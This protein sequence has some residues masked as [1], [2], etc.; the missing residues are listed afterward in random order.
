MK[1]I[2][3][4][5]ILVSICFLLSIAFTSSAQKTADFSLTLSPNPTNYTGYPSTGILNARLTYPTNAAEV[6]ANTFAVIVTAGG[7]VEFNISGYTP[8]TG[9]AIDVANTDAANVVFYNTAALVT[10]ATPLTFAIPTKAVKAGSTVHGGDIQP[11]GNI[12]YDPATSNNLP[13]VTVNVPA[14]PLPVTLISFNAIKENNTANLSWSTSSEV[15]SNRFEI[16][17]SVDAKQWKVVGTVASYQN[18]TIRQNYTFNHS[19]PAAGDNYY[20]LKMIDNDETFAFSTIK[21]LT[22]DQSLSLTL[23]PNPVSDELKLDINDWT[24]VK[25]IQIYNLNGSIVFDAGI[26]VTDKINVQNLSSGVYLVNVAKL[27]GSFQS[28][29]FVINR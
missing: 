22:F 2:I 16:Q 7:A 18:S 3:T 21:T 6:P 25:K 12:W 5:K 19:N 24:T 26:K 4:Q 23:Y 9:W 10:R 17:Q 27:D 14:T 11:I 13:S 29:R 28:A 1:N 8:P 20:R 15:N